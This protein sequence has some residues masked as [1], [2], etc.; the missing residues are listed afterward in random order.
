MT[1]SLPLGAVLVAALAIGCGS[2]STAPVSTGSGATLAVVNA[3]RALI[4]VSID[5]VPVKTGLGISGVSTQ[6]VSVGAHTVHFQM[7]GSSG[8]NL[9]IS[10]A[11]GATVTAVAQSSIEGALTADT[12]ADTGAVA[13]AGK[14]KLRVVHM[15]G[16]VQ[17]VDIWRTQPD[18]QTPIRIMFP[19]PYAS[20]SPYLQSDAGVWNVYITS[21][22]DWNTK[23]ADAGQISIP[24]G[25]VKSVILVDSAGVPRLRVVTDR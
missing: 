8:I 25:G 13:P 10:A 6:S 14:S 4:D 1:R 19:F 21:T 5:G 9:A 18:Y 16:S 12:L 17:A 3:S 7:S 22:T 15:D 20:Q 11:A 24:S 23:L 2:D